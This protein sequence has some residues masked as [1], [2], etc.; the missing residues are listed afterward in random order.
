MSTW[1]A[2]VPAIAVL[3]GVGIVL[4]DPLLFTHLSERISQSF[5]AAF[6]LNT[7]G[8]ET[9]VL[10]DDPVVVYIKDFITVDEAAHLVRLAYVTSFPAR[11][12][13]I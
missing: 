7:Q 9:F 5:S 3:L 8:P 4:I 11:G 13:D 12:D 6:S 10:S 1:R 2:I